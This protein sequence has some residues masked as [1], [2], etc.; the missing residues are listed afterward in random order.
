[1]RFARLLMLALGFLA[2]GPAAADVAPPA[3]AVVLTVSGRID[4]GTSDVARFDMEMLRALPAREFTTSTIWT[5]GAHR[6][7]G[8]PLATLLDAVAADGTVLKAT[9]LNDYSIEI[10]IADAVPE[11]PIIAYEFDGREM[12]VREKGPL[13]IVYPFDADADY[14]T[15]S[16]YSRSIW[17]LDRIE[18]VK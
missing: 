16:V 2:A 3:G 9:A 15:E 17:Q 18:V 11:G 12:S 5:E 8:V 6:F 7:R 10:P 4:A 1:M 14:R 13:W